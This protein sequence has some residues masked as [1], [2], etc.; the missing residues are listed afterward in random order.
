MYRK[1]NRVIRYPKFDIKFITE[2]S[3]HEVQYDTR[4]GKNPSDD[5]MGQSVVSLTTKNSME[6]DSAVFSFVLSGN[7]YWDRVLG[8][9]DAVILKITPDTMKSTADQRDI[10]DV[11]LVGLVSEVRL[12]ADY[13]DNSKMY[14]I[15]GQSFAKSLISFDIGVIQQVSVVLTEIGWLPD[16]SDKGLVFSGQNAS[17]IAKSMMDRFLT[18]TRYKFD[19]GRTIKDFLVYDN[20]DS[21]TEYESLT[22]PSPFINYEG[23]LKQLID[24]VTEKPFN[25]LFFDFS[26]DEKCHMIM[27]RTPFDEADWNRL[28]AHQI[29]SKAVLSESVAKGDTEAYS[30][31]NVLSE[32]VLG[33]DSVD[34]G[35]FPRY[36]QS[37]VDKYGYSKLEIKNRYLMGSIDATS[38]DFTSSTADAPEGEEMLVEATAYSY[39]E[40]GLSYFTKDGTDLRDRPK[41]IAV[42]PS[43]IPLGSQVWIEGFGNYHAGDTGGDIKGK[44]I[45][46]HMTSVQDC[47]N[48]GRKQ[49][50]IVIKKKGTTSRTST[51]NT[52]AN[53]HATALGYL[54]A[55]NPKTLRVRKA[56]ISAKIKS[57]DPRITKT[58]AD[59]VVDTFIKQNTLSQTQFSDITG[60]TLKN[61]DEKGDL[62]MTYSKL[63]LFLRDYQ[64]K[65]MKDRDLVRGAIMEEFDGVTLDQATSLATSF[66]A[67]GGNLTKATYDRILTGN[68]GTDGPSAQ[69]INT[70]AL[71]LFTQK[72]ANWYSENVNFYAGDIKVVGS[73]DYRIGNRLLYTDEQNNELWEYYIEGVQHDYSYTSGF[74]T[75]LSVTRGLQ[76]GGISRFT[77]LWGKSEEFK[78][79]LLGERSLDDLYQEAQ[80]S[81]GSDSTSSSG[82]SSSSGSEGGKSTH[83]GSVGTSGVYQ[84][85]VNIA[86]KAI[87]KNPT[88]RI[89]SG[90]RPND[91]AYHGRRQAIDIAFPPSMNGS[92]QNRVVANW[93]FETFPNEVSYVITN[94]QVRD[95]SGMSGAGTSGKWVPWADNDHYD[96][97]HIN[98]MLGEGEIKK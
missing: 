49:V 33:R 96:H 88:M 97:I 89:T 34:F 45:D 57:L 74:V 65:T 4:V 26:K 80:E 61:A 48:F 95:R 93:I 18:Y 5:L 84:Y 27:R 2:D 6:D 90:Y 73:P 70:E 94:G 44:R 30:I 16:D 87:Q 38:D 8:P 37:L 20:L 98:G 11:I 12:E 53:I 42:D 55:Q 15:S 86:N 56:V 69:T 21:W 35:S 81:T 40:A 17:A 25:E 23:S 32:D 29:T 64:G 46:I 24:D 7:V 66:L 41:V 9:N 28:P 13:G 67:S 3:V 47:I 54:K 22:D 85:L 52:L 36:F 60:I 50:K 79:G 82:G 39:N 1:E 91:P 78:G 59:K 75:S 68:T 83:D 72:L 92:P 10:N 63:R 58:E 43:V 19:K 77:N 31:F 62:V 14:R 76:E 51:T 71:K